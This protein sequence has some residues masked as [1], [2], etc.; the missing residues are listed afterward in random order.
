M[1]C[2]L[3]DSPSP[4]SA[5][6]KHITNIRPTNQ[7]HHIHYRSPPQTHHS[8]CQHCSRSVSHERMTARP[9][10]CSP[11]P[12][13]T[14]RLTSSPRRDIRAKTC[15]VHLGSQSNPHALASLTL[16]PPHL[17]GPGRFGTQNSEL[18]PR[19]PSPSLRL[20]A[21]LQV[22]AHSPSNVRTRV[23]A[24]VLRLQGLG[25]SPT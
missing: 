25:M 13:R 15:R 3:L 8:R 6:G 14:H 16:L 24:E 2:D 19:E 17:P 10:A 9:L 20:H 23:D 11:P 5:T 22:R 18:R 12:S 1:C 7:R 21:G 4:H